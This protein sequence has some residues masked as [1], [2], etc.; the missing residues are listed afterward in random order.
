VFFAGAGVFVL[1][2]NFREHVFFYDSGLELRKCH[3]SF[4]TA[5]NTKTTM[6]LER[7]EMDL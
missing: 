5:V 1:A 7:P 3:S 4:N 2:G 6:Y